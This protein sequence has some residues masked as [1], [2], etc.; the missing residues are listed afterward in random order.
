MNNGKVA[1]EL[2]K[3]AREIKADINLGEIKEVEVSAGEGPTSYV[4]CYHKLK[5]KTVRDAEKALISYP[6]PDVDEGY[7]KFDIVLTFTDGSTYKFRYD[8]GE[9]DGRLSDQ[10]EARC[11]RGY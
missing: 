6:K 10:V 7:Y 2:K 1:N 3:I 4:R 5:F 9:G 11:K 8:H